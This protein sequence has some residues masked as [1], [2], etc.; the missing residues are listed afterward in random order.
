ML[1]EMVFSSKLAEKGKL[2]CEKGHRPY[3]IIA[4]RGLCNG[5]TV[6]ALARFTVMLGSSLAYSLQ[7][8]R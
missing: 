7:A 8:Q 6:W 2:S 1:V 5:L 3:R 4:F